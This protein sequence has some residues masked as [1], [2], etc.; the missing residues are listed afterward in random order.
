MPFYRIIGNCK[1]MGYFS[2]VLM[3]SITLELI[4]FEKISE[5]FKFYCF[6]FFCLIDM[7]WSHIFSGASQ[8]I[9]LSF[10]FI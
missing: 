2:G 4:F 10:S 3:V 5:F 8:V 9:L 1:Q 6:C 7:D